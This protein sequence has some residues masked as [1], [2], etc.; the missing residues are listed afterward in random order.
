MKFMCIEDYWMFNEAEEDGDIPA[1]KAGEVYFFYKDEHSIDHEI[2][3]DR[4]NHGDQHYM[5]I[6]DTFYKY[7][8]TSEG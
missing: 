6:C 1:F 8:I 4:D 7:F 5:R 3:T 2:V